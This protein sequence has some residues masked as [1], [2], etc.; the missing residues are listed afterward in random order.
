MADHDLR[1]DPADVICPFCNADVGAPCQY[2]NGRAMVSD[3]SGLRWRFH[4]ERSAKWFTQAG[5]EV[6]R[7]LARGRSRG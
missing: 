1:G 7:R 4:R 6:P 5:L 2:A 3:Q